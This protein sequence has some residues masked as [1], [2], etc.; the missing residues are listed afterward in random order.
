MESDDA[1]DDLTA[2]REARQHADETLRRVRAQRGD[3]E[4]M[5]RALQRIR[6]QNHLLDIVEASIRDRRGD[7]RA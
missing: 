6:S 3:V 1:E 2:A 4:R 7:G 5:T